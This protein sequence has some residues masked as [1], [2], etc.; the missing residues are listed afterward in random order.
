MVIAIDICIST[1]TVA[2]ATASEEVTFRELPSLSLPFGAEGIVVVY[3]SYSN[4]YSS[5]VGL[6][7]G[8]ID[9]TSS[10]ISRVTKAVC[11]S[12]AAG[13][14]LAALKALFLLAL[15]ASTTE[16]KESVDWLATLY[17][18]IYAF[19]SIS[20]NC[21]KNSLLLNTKL[22]YLTQSIN[23]T[24]LQTLGSTTIRGRL[25]MLLIDSRIGF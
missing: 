16:T 19:R 22:S 18:Y 21:D 7:V 13:L 10:P 15:L 8:T 4:C 25:Y 3:H 2:I 23:S 24:Y 6:F 20:C 5:R 1:V 17:F 14:I 12:K 11:V 9:I